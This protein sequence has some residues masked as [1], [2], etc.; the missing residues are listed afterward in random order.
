MK[1]FLTSLILA[2]LAAA[3]AW[4]SNTCIDSRDIVS[5]KSD[6]GKTMVF[7][8]RDGHIYVNH[9]QGACPGLKF[10]GYSWTLR[11]GDTKVCEREQTLRVLRSG[12]VCVL[13]AF[14]PPRMSKGTN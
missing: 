6:D 10:D 1:M 5:S 3:P 12:E 14:D 7:K 9:L 2:G 11:D 4:A 13:G 8:M